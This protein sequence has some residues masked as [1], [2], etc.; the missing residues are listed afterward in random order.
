MA[1]AI[2]SHFLS[3][4]SYPSTNKDT[5]CKECWAPFDYFYSVFEILNWKEDDIQNV[6]GYK[7]FQLPFWAKIIYRWDNHAVEICVSSKILICQQLLPVQRNL[8]WAS[9]IE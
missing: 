6:L 3:V 4:K 5:R 9:Q 8:Y 2:F 1:V 7:F